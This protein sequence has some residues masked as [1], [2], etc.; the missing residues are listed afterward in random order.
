MESSLHN[1]AAMPNSFKLTSHSAPLDEGCAA[2]L[3]AVHPLRASEENYYK[4]Q[5]NLNLHMLRTRQGLHAPLTLKMEEMAVKKM[6]RLPILRSSNASYDSLTGRDL[7]MDF[8]DFLGQPE[9]SEL[10][11]QPH[12]LM[13][14]QLGL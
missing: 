8:T 3:I 13:E 7:M 14:K 1:V 6:G 5:Q 12:A 2:Q 11:R 10:M 9:H 4:N